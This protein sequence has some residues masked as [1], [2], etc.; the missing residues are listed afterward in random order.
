MA[1][2]YLLRHPPENP[3]AVYLT[4]YRQHLRI[5]VSETYK[6]KAFLEFIANDPRFGAEVFRIY[7]PRLGVETFLYYFRHLVVCS[8]TSGA[9]SSSL[10]S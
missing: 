10:C 3:A 4:P 6:R 2:K 9:L 7:N 5:G 1:K 8:H